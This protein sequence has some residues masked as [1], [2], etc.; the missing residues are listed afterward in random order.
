[1]CAA[2]D[3]PQKW[4]DLGK[5]LM[6]NA[7]AELSIISNNHRDIVSCCSRMFQI[8]L[9]RQPN[10]SWK[11]L[12]EALKEVDLNHLATQ[13]EGMLMPSND[14]AAASASVVPAMPRECM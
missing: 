8:W 14:T 6:P 4:K 13:I 1:M 5:V 10:A 12:I 9:E 7:V 2:C 3:N 11:Q